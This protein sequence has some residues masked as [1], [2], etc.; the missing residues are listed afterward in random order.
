MHIAML[1]LGKMGAN[2]AQR[3]LRGG[4][5]V[6]AYDINPAA[7]QAVEAMGAQGAASLEALAAGL[8]APRSVWMMLPAGKITENAIRALAGL[9]SR[10]D[11][12]ID[13]GNSYY[14]DSQRR[15]AELAQQGIDF[16]DAG[17]S[18]GIWGL[19]QGY[20]LMVGGAAEVVERH[21]PLFETLAPAKDQGWGRVGPAGAGHF[22]KMIHNGIEYGLMQAYGEGFEILKAKEEFDLDLHQVS[23]I[24]RTGSVI[25]SWLLDLTSLALAEDPDLKGIAPWVADSGEGRWTTFEAIDLDVSAPVI[26]L[27]LQQRI[28]SRDE[29]PFSARLVAAMRR[30]FGGHSVKPA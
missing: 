22:V 26:T 25:R 27:S 18:G 30:E 15:A 9:L 5:Q 11:T 20:S 21:R 4:H 14:K 24:W 3:L 12:I 1:G 2:M 17:T 13:G 16:I 6:L 23:E 19:E 10:G 7:V 29:D 28:R 8:P